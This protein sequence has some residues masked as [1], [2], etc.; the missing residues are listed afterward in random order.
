MY[1]HHHN[2]H[3]SVTIAAPWVFVWVFAMCV[4]EYMS[5]AMRENALFFFLHSFFLL[6]SNSDAFVFAKRFSVWCIRAHYMSI[7][8]TIYII[9]MQKSMLSVYSIVYS[10]LVT[11]KYSSVIRWSESMYRVAIPFSYTVC[12]M[13]YLNNIFTEPKKR[14]KMWSVLCYMVLRQFIF[15]ICRDIL[16]FTF[17][18]IAYS[19]LF[20][21]W[22]FFFSGAKT[23]LPNKITQ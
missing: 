21:C 5:A 17:T 20:L 23:F 8:W 12:E 16:D 13:L 2:F 9:A 11:P 15:T 18:T 3:P 19:F 7:E 4:Y 14:D 6:N 1:F 22:F 10:L